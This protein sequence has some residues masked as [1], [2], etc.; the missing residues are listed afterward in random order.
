VVEAEVAGQQSED[1]EVD[2]VAGA[3]DQAEL[4]EL[5]PVRGLPS[6]RADPICDFAG[7]THQGGQT[8]G[9]SGRAG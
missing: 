9:R 1:A 6:G 2:Q 4:E 5:H 7:T 3:A 8:T